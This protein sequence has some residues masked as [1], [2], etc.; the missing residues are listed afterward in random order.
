MGEK[1]VLVPKA[2]FH[3]KDMGVRGKSING[4]TVTFF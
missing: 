3:V 2:T 4:Y 1:I